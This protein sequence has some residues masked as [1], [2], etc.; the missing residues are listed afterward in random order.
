MIEIFLK[1]LGTLLSG[2][3]GYLFLE[4]LKYVPL[5]EWKVFY[6]KNVIPFLWTLYGSILI[7]IIYSFLPQFMPFVENHVGGEIEIDNYSSLILS[8]GVIGAL[9]KSLFV[10]QQKAAKIN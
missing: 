2:A 7:V 5:F 8:G 10:K 1:L 4:A 3:L 9:L 6:K